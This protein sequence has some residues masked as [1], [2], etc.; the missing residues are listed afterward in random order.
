MPNPLTIRGDLP[1]SSS[2]T[3]TN[4]PTPETTCNP[5]SSWQAARS[6]LTMRG[7]LPPSSRVTG[8]TRLAPAAMI[9]LPI[10]VE[11]VKAVEQEGGGQM[12]VKCWHM[13]ARRLLLRTATLLWREDSC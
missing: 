9:S 4:R 3:G 6:P 13:P 11:P 7:D 2:A 8:T 12:M 10:S 1:S 5:P